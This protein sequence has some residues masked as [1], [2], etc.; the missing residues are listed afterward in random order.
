MLA[1]ASVLALC[2][3]AVPAGVLLWRRAFETLPSDGLRTLRLVHEQI[4]NEHVEPQDADAL[5]DDAIRGM[6]GELDRFSE[7]VPAD[8]VEDF[9]ARELDGTYVG[10]G[11]LLFPDMS[12]ATVQS[13][14]AGGSAAE[15]GVLPGDRLIRIADEDVA[16]LAAGEATETAVR[17]LRGVAGTG[18]T[19]RVERLSDDGSTEELSFELERRAVPQ[20]RV[21][22]AHLAD[23]DQ[24][25]GYIHISGFQ[26]GMVDDFDARLA[27][28][29]SEG[30]LAGLCLDLRHNPGGL[31]T[32]AVALA[33]RFVAEGEL[34][35]LK[36]RR[37]EVLER[38]E[39]VAA[40]CT[41]PDLPLVVLVDEGTASASEVVTGALQDLGRATVVGT[42]SYGKGVVQSIYSWSGLPF[43]LK[44]TT[45]R[46]YT[47]SGRSLERSLRHPDDGEDQ[48]GIIPDETVPLDADAARRLAARLAAHEVRPPYRDRAA[49][50]AAA[51]DRP[52]ASPPDP[53]EDT[54]LAAALEALERRI[55]A[56]AAGESG[57]RR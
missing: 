17:L 44:L 43:R 31:L 22:W 14:L 24:R 35:T 55:P 36:R 16:L 1:A 11:V 26:R 37:G 8:D 23:A 47:P 56:E 39:A 41:H 29:E 13:P 28:L 53:R 27:E 40:T 54:Q 9:E 7:F 25:F 38:H 51:L 32:E 2:F 57:E 18:V 45:A 30:P 12:P 4:L 50:V 10:V 48:G 6:V 19:V 5:L 46:Y 49:R 52:L 33:N 21:K 20:S 34:V 3:V 42:R 15:R